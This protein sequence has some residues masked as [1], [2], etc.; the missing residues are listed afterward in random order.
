MDQE[1][2][3][4]EER[5]QLGP[6]LGRGTFGVVHRATRRRDGA[7][8][9]A[10]VLHQ[11]SPDARAR[12]R[13]EAD[14]VRDLEHP[15]LVRLQGVFGDVHGDP[16]LVYDLVD[17]DTLEERTRLGPADPATLLRWTRE[18]AAALEALHG[19]GLV[20]RDLKPENV[21][22]D[23]AGRVRLLDYGLARPEQQ[24]RTMTAEGL[25]LGTPAYM[26]PE[27]FDGAR[28]SPADDVY[29]LACLVYASLA[30]RPAHGGATPFEVLGAKRSPPPRLPRLAALGAPQLNS[31]DAVFARALSPVAG[32]RY[33]GPG[34][35]SSAVERALAG[36]ASEPGPTLALRGTPSPPPPARLAGPHA[37]AAP[38]STGLFLRRTAWRVVP[39]L[40]AVALVL[41]GVLLGS[42][43]GSRPGPGEPV[44]RSEPAEISPARQLAD[45]VGRE[46]AAAGDLWIDEAGAVH[47]RPASGLV[48]PGGRALLGDDPFLFAPSLEHMP[49][50]QGHL[51]A[52]ARGEVEWHALPEEDRR[53]LLQVSADF[54]GQGLPDP[55]WPLLEVR[56][57]EQPAPLDDPF[58][59]DFRRRKFDLFRHEIPSPDPSPW[60]R[61]VWARVVQMRRLGEALEEEL[62]SSSSPLVEELGIQNAV[63]MGGDPLVVLGAHVHDPALRPQLN[64]A[65]RKERRAYQATL[66]AVGR[67]VRHAS[68][69]EAEE[70]VHMLWE[71][72]ADYR[73]LFYG[74]LAQ[75]APEALLGIPGTTP[76]GARAVFRISETQRRTRVMT[77]LTFLNDGP[78]RLAELADRMLDGPLETGFQLGRAKAGLRYFEE[79]HGDHD[80][81]Y[82]DRRERLLARLTEPHHEWLR[83][84]L[85]GV[86]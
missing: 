46:L 48:P 40:A 66:W 62:D 60:L 11:A 77:P 20:H 13:R 38:M 25:V 24:G 2:P 36:E 15:H 18:L 68:A 50:L 78:H 70:A 3:G 23:E 84:E 27:V 7:A 75:V 69:R 31:L 19:A 39:V 29:A 6:E 42:R 63:F 67:A 37:A 32:D 58:H 16:V 33:P 74:H 54:Q 79:T 34:A 72:A 10:K 61:T 83:G 64:R 26:A 76:A 9:A 41:L 22:I 85:L 57:G 47:P 51:A 28:P 4:F 35:L 14:L 17:G 1:L 73:F 56:R 52:R 12:V 49:A 55:F 80:R 82:L 59:E 5:Y 21:M 8:A 81:R 86:R 71:I 65:L 45:E 30:G 44:L 53:A 43:P